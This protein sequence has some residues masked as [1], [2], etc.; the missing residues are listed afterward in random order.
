MAD[1]ENQMTRELLERRILPIFANPAL[2]SC[3]DSAT[4]R[5]KGGRLAFAADFPVKLCACSGQVAGHI[6]HRHRS[7]DRR[8]ECARG[9]MADLLATFVLGIERCAVAHRCT[10]FGA[11]A[12]AGA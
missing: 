12:H 6:G 11:Q 10:A 1:G 4:L 9:H 2:D 8:P 7:F 3:H 5:A